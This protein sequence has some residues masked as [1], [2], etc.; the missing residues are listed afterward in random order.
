MITLDD[1]D[2]PDVS[3]VSAQ[4]GQ[5]ASTSP[6][7]DPYQRSS[8]IQMTTGPAVAVPGG[9][10]STL[11]IGNTTFPAGALSVSNDD[12]VA[13]FGQ[14]NYTLPAGFFTLG[15]N[16]YP[17]GG[18]GTVVTAGTPVDF[19]FNV[20]RN[21]LP[22]TVTVFRGAGSTMFNLPGGL[23]NQPF[24]VPLT[25][26]DFAAIDAGGTFAIRLTSNVPSWDASIDSIGFF[27]PEP[28]SFALAGLALVAAGLAARRRKA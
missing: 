2:T 20:R 22:I 15:K 11:K 9:A 7:A 8:F 21:D 3:L 27:V 16:G 13:S 10:V 23:L 14:V 28:G 17:N 18:P 19:F 24:Q 1:F 4:L 26:A 5:L 12:G 6:G 25:A